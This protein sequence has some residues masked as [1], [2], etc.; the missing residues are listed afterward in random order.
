MKL[1]YLLEKL[2]EVSEKVKSSQPMICGGVPR[3][4][5]MNR[6]DNISDLDITTGDK[7]I[8]LLAYEFGNLLEKQYNV[9]NKFHDDGHSSIHIGSFKV[10]FSSNFNLPNIEQILQKMAVVNPTNIQKEMFSRD[11]TCNALLLSTDLKSISDPTQ[12]GF[13]DIDDK[14]V[15]TC[16]SPELTL[17]SNKNRVIRAI[18]LAAKLDFNIDPAIVEFVAAR[19]ETVKIASQKVLIEKINNS[20]EKDPDKTSFYLDKMKLWPLIPITEKARPYYLKYQNQGSVNKMAYF[21]GGGGVNEPEPKKKKYPSEK[22]EKVEPRFDE[23]FYRNYDLYDVPGPGPGGGYHTIQRYKSISE[24]LKNKRK[25]QNKSNIKVRAAFLKEAIDFPN[26]QYINPG[27]AIG[28][29]DNMM[30]IINP[31]G[32][33][34][35]YLPLDDFEGKPP[36]SLD[37]ATRKYPENSEEACLTVEDIESILDQY[38]SHGLYGL[39]D[40]VDISEEELGQPNDENPFYGTL[41]PNTLIYENNSRI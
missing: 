29:S 37:F 2:N 11:F 30:E 28:N 9:V 24:F 8:Q 25:K 26:D 41:G 18:Y 20:F 6:L 39:P 31:I 16:L 7:T 36:T 19:P 17:T 12:R 32:Y 38:L 3:D 14:I 35:K 4:R 33:L 23:P 1:R 5:F 40:G 22:A 27:L 13:D 10:D 15:R 21:Q 34:D